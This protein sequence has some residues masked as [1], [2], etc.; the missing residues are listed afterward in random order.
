MKEVM[1]KEKS[2]LIDELFDPTNGGREEPTIKKF[3]S[4]AVP[5]P[6]EQLGTA[7]NGQKTQSSP[8]MVQFSEEGK[9]FKISKGMTSEEEAKLLQLVLD[10]GGILKTITSTHDINLKTNFFLRDFFSLTFDYKKECHDISNALVSL[11]SKIKSI[12]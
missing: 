11:S 8:P 10:C 12:H 9:V 3:P 1:P 5:E 2:A 7:G 4:Q 6:Q